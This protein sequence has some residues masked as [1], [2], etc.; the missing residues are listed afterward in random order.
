MRINRNDAD[1]T[2]FS[3]CDEVSFL[4]ALSV[5][6]FFWIF[7]GADVTHTSHICPLI[8]AI[9]FPATPFIDLA[10][11]YLITLC[12]QRSSQLI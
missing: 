3:L 1:S 10:V 11:R 8:K 12:Y 7:Q 6:H 4:H 5:S 9:Y 2:S